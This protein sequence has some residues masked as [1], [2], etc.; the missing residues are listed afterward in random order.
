MKRMLQN[1]ILPELLVMTT[2]ITL[3]FALYHYGLQAAALLLAGGLYILTHIKWFCANQAQ[4]EYKWLY[5]AECRYTSK[6]R[7]YYWEG[8]PDR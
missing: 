8:S 6:L 2:T 7:D 1:P 5:D 3:V 4:K